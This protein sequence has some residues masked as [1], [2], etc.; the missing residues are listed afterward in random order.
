MANI[1]FKRVY[2]YICYV[3]SGK[4]IGT[5]PTITIITMSFSWCSMGAR[6]FYYST[7]QR[8]NIPVYIYIYYWLVV[9]S[10]APQKNKRDWGSSSHF[11][12]ELK[13]KIFETTS[14]WSILAIKLPIISPISVVTTWCLLL[15]QP[16][17]T[18]ISQSLI[19]ILLITVPSEWIIICHQ[20]EIRLFGD[21]SPYNS[22][23]S[24]VRS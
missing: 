20:P 13:R 5:L 1:H 8:E 14:Q 15:N 22:H 19:I 16:S 18:L 11:Y 9:S 2:I 6:P 24:R 4:N 17:T 23:D 10:H 7:N 12:Q 3:C 21:D